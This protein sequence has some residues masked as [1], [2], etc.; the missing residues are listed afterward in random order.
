MFVPLVLVLGILLLVKADAPLRVL[1]A[2]SE[3]SLERHARSVRD[4]Y[5]ASNGG[6]CPSWTRWRR[7]RA[8]QGFVVTDV[9]VE[10]KSYGFAY[11]P[12]R[13]PDPAEERYEHFTGP[14][15]IWCDGP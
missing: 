3:P 15:Y 12:D 13:A 11:L 14:W 7:F 9:T 1:F 4:D 2:L 5:D 6:V 10:W 8:E